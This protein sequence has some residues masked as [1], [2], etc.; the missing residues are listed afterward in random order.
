[1]KILFA[2]SPQAAL[3]ALQVVS[4]VAS[5]LAVMSQP[6][7]PTGRKKILTPT[8]VSNWALH[9]DLTLYRPHTKEEIAAAV[10]EFQPELG[11]TVAY[12]K[13][14]TPEVLALP[15]DGWWNV[16]FSLLPRYRGAAPVQHALLAGDRETG[17]SIF[18]LDAGIDT[19]PVI[20]QTTHPMMPGI[21]SGELLDQLAKVAAALL[22]QTL[23]G[24]AADNISTAT[25]SGDT[26]HAPK[27]DATTGH[28]RSHHTAIEAGRLFQ[29]TTPEPGCFVTFNQGQ[30]RLRILEARINED[31]HNVRPGTIQ[32]FTDGVGIALHGG[33]V[34]LQ[35][36][37]PA[38][39]N[40]MSSADWWRGVQKEAVID[41]S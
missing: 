22:T 34:M 6:D 11:I 4:D 14:L 1:M 19:G 26:S 3:P 37:Q 7:K 36:V 2:G 8:P 13:I 29:A 15:R 38:G 23:R 32:V 27:L 35:R 31:K 5:C 9:N 24:Y 10:A 12:G 39:K 30:Q 33:V 28:I 25:Q 41:G 40:P 20:S 17:V 18:Q 16:H 21:T